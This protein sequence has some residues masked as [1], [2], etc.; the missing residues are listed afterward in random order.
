M[1]VLSNET[2]DDKGWPRNNGKDDGGM[3]AYIG[4]NVGDGR[5]LF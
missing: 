2:R 5:I 1:L 3:I 4:K